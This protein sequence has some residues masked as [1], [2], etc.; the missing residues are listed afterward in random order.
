VNVTTL[1]RAAVIATV[2]AAFVPAPA[3]AG[4]W[5]S[6]PQLERQAAAVGQRVAVR[7][8]VLFSSEAVAERAADRR[9]FVYL[10]RG[11]GERRLQRA[12]PQPASGDRWSL[13]AATA[14]RAGEARLT[15][16]GSSGRVRASLRV[17]ATLGRYAVMLCDRGCRAP[18]ADVVPARFTAVADPETARL[19]AQAARVRNRA[20]GE[21]RRLAAVQEAGRRTRAATA[22]VAADV[23]RLEALVA[24][25]RREAASPPTF[26]LLPVAICA[27]LA[28]L[29][30][31]AVGAALVR[32]SRPR[33]RRI[34][35]GSVAPSASRS[36][37]TNGTVYVS[38]AR[39][40]A[41][42]SSR[43]SAFARSAASA[44]GRRST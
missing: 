15:V 33:R 19:L 10:V 32:R 28:A 16:D 5:W 30:G 13:G 26:P 27:A 20:F 31:A 7:A 22:E 41:P 35:S 36:F 23:A 1:V 3:A 2:T 18:L 44:S 12:V 40:K 25:L 4:G 39:F 11:L 17:P 21:R 24:S 34:L 29:A 9:W 14:I 42:S 43:H 6:Y 37:P 38:S 8:E